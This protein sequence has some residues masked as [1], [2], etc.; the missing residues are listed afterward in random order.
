MALMLLVIGFDFSALISMLK[1]FDVWSMRSTSCASS[2]SLPARPSM[3]SANRKLVVVRAAMLTVPSCYSS[4]SDIILSRKML[5]R[6]D[7][8]PMTDTY[9]SV[10]PLSMWFREDNN[11]RDCS[12]E[13]KQREA[14]TRMREGHHICLR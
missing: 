7:N 5:K 14:N 1:V 4:T 10:E 13:E 12:S 6:V 2:C 8:I 11:V 9:Y 3:S